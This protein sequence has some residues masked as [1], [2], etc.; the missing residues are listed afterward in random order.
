MSR[1]RDR[2]ELVVH[3]YRR[4]Q[5]RQ[6]HRHFRQTEVDRA[7]EQPALKDRAAFDLQ[8]QL[9]FQEQDVPAEWQD[10]VRK[11]AEFYGR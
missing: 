10:F 2:H 1:R 7:V 5:L 4:L 8:A 6:R 11:N 3:E 9:I